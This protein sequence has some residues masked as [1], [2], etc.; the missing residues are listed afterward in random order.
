VAGKGK[1]GRSSTYK[2]RERRRPTL[3]GDEREGRK[4]GDGNRGEGIL[5]ESR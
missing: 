5:P 4:R 1:E 2:G 3:N